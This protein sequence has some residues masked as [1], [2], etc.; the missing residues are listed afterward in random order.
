[1]SSFVDG[2]MLKAQH[3][4]S[5]KDAAAIRDLLETYSMDFT[6]TPATT[7][8]ITG[9][10]QIP[11]AFY[12][13]M[14]AK[15]QDGKMSARSAEQYSM[16]L[17]DMLQYLQ[18]PLERITVNHIRLYLNDLNR[19]NGKPLAAATMNQRKS[20]IKSFFGWLT[21]EEYI[22]K[23][24]TLRIKREKDNAKPR[25]AYKDIQIEEIRDGVTNKRDRAIVDLLLSSGIR[26]SECAG[27]KRSDIDF[28]ERTAKVYGKGGK[29]RTAYF[30]GRT[31]YSLKEYLRTRDDDSTALFVSVRKPHKP[32]SARAIEKCLK[33]CGNRVGIEQVIPHRF[34]HTM[35]TTAIDRGMPLESVQ[36]LLGHARIETTMHYVH[37]TRAKVTRDYQTYLN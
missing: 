33:K 2:F 4:L 34:R 14:A 30:D 8:M 27:L 10:Y 25:E 31:E 5:P 13:F 37:M 1:M 12:I 11:Q 9:C 18:M 29:W 23:N 24:P 16:C 36:A 6:I 35:A 32:I 3:V 28:A 21:E 22:E 15:E 20:I 26:V 19:R 7:E 17:V